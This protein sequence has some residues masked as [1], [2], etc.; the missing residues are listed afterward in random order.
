MITWVRLGALG[1]TLVLLSA[2]AAGVSQTRPPAAFTSYVVNEGSNTVTAFNTRTG[3]VVKT[4]KVG[5]G[6]TAIAITSDGTT[7]YVANAGSD[8]VTPINTATQR[9]GQAIKVGNQ[10]LGIAITPDGRTLYVTNFGS[11]T[12][13]PVSTAT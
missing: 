9:A 12:V 10:P 11:G 5:A 7:A 6:P 13:T 1:L 2:C 3:R 4:I 8:T